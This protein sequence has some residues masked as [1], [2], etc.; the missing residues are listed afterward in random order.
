LLVDAADPDGLAHA[1]CQILGNRER[2]R[3]MGNE[4][5]RKAMERF[6]WGRT[7]DQLL[8]KFRLLQGSGKS[9]RADIPEQEM[10]V[11]QARPFDKQSTL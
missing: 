11:G 3:E 2:A 10:A 8:E 7:A 1:M 6:S 5:R 4:G 9:L